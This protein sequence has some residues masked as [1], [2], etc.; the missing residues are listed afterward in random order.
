MIG[1]VYALEEEGCVLACRATDGV[2][3]RWQHV[4]AVLTHKSSLHG[5]ATL[6]YTPTMRARTP[7]RLLRPTM[8]LTTVSVRLGDR[9][10]LLH[11]KKKRSFSCFLLLRLISHVS[12]AHLKWHLSV[13][14]RINARK[15]DF[16]RVL[17]RQISEFNDCDLFSLDSCLFL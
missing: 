11:A 12:R 6:R 10:W 8:R 13:G 2:L 1:S 9:C 14:T 16:G 5:A 4:W 7:A 15:C 3:S 17:A